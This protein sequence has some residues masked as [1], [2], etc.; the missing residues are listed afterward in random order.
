MIPEI[1]R[2]GCKVKNGGTKTY[3]QFTSF[4]KIISPHQI[5]KIQFKTKTL[6][7]LIRTV[8]ICPI[9]FDAHQSV[10]LAGLQAAFVERDNKLCFMSGF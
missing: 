9:D 1:A 3:K 4:Q 8:S 7:T 10:F 2:I 6:P 5:V